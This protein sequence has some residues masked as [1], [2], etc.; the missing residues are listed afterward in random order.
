MTSNSS[1]IDDT[2]IAIDGDAAN[3]PPTDEIDSIE[4]EM[5][6]QCFSKWC[7]AAS[8]ASVAAYY[9][10]S[11]PWEQCTIANQEL[12]RPDC[13][14]R[15]CHEDSAPFNV[16]NTLG[17]PLHRIQHLDAVRYRRVR[18]D[19]VRQEL[20]RSRP[21]CARTEWQGGGGHF[22]AIVAYSPT[23]DMISIRD[24]LHG[25]N[26]VPFDRFCNDYPP[27]GGRWTHT[28]FT[29]PAD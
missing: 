27:S 16:L 26:Q 21:L 7:W 6:E 19:E 23:S 4:F 3:V 28:Y 9:A 14:E 24:P 25:P 10:A 13:C 5:Q 18:R 11:S 20:Q 1:I 8:A 12:H 15:P 17:S 22:V 29:R 2:R